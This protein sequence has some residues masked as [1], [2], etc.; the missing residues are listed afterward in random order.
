M[1]K[2]TYYNEKN[3]NSELTFFI[4]DKSEISFFIDQFDYPPNSISLDYTDVK[5][6]IIELKKLID[7]YERPN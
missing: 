3:V 4:N 2:T 6:M 1:K 5:D 7:L